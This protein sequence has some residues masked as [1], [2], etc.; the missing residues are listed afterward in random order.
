M[1][2]SVSGS[3]VQL[4]ENF[5]VVQLSKKKYRWSSDFIFFELPGLDPLCC[6][7]VH[8]NI[9]GFFRKWCMY[10]TCIGNLFPFLSRWGGS[11]SSCSRDGYWRVR[12]RS[13]EQSLP[14]S[15]QDPA[16]QE[17]RCCLCHRLCLPQQGPNGGET[18]TFECIDCGVHVYRLVYVC[19]WERIADWLCPPLKEQ[20][21]CDRAVNFP[22][23]Y[24][25]L[26]SWHEVDILFPLFHRE[27]PLHQQRPLAIEPSGHECP[28]RATTCQVCVKSPQLGQGEC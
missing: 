12:T 27:L 28:V 23:D 19:E 16:S 22:V 17:N 10:S 14:A 1:V 5:L 11:C 21:F 2:R 26:E 4:L 20:W 8:W 6:S 25:V 24:L 3:S 13:S 15:T 18:E 7:F 9:W